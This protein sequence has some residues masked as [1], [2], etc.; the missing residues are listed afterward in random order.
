MVRRTRKKSSRKESD[1]VKRY[2]KATRKGK[3][4]KRRRG[5]AKGILSQG[6]RRKLNQHRLDQAIQNEMTHRDMKKLRSQI[7]GLKLPP[8]SKKADDYAKRY[9][10]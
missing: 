2:R 10:E 1:P 4:S 7:P 8:R 9:G 3:K 6:N 5:G